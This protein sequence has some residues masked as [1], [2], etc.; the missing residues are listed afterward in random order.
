M[1]LPDP[2][3]FE[4]LLRQQYEPILTPEDYAKLRR[5]CGLG[6]VI[7]GEVVLPRREI[8]AGRERP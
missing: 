2:A 4:R 3:D 6:D 7:D 1:E 8:A 5:K